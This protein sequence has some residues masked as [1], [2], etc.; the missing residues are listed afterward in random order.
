MITLQERDSRAIHCATLSWLLVGDIREMLQDHLDEEAIQWLQPVLDALI[1]AMREQASLEE[2]PGYFDDV[3]D[4]CPHWSPMVDHIHAEQS[5]L[6]NSLASLR[7][8]FNCDLPFQKLANALESELE[9][10]VR[11]MTEHAEREREMMQ[12]VWYTEIGGEG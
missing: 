3:L 9:A 11:L 4:S 1:E 5:A 8:R 7:H 2:S 10:W 6:C 12:D